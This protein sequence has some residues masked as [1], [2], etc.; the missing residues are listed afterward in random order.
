M[1]TRGSLFARM[2]LAAS[3]WLALSIGVVG[4]TLLLVGLPVYFGVQYGVEAALSLPVAHFLSAPIVTAVVATLMLSCLVAVAL[5]VRTVRTARDNAAPAGALA[6]GAVELAA[7]V[8]LLSSLL[9]ALA[10]VPF[11]RSVL[12]APLFALLILLGFL[13]LLTAGY[14]LAAYQWVHSRD[15]VDDERTTGGSYLV[16]GVFVVAYL[17]FSVWH[18]F[19]FLAAVALVWLV[20]AVLFAPDH[21][22]AVRDAI[23]R[24]AAESADEHPVDATAVYG[25]TDEAKRIRVSLEEATGMHPGILVAVAG[26]AVVSGSYLLAA[27]TSVETTA[28]AVTTL[29]GVAFIGIHV[30]STVRAETTGNSAVL[31]DLEDRFSLEPLETTEAVHTAAGTDADTALESV[32]TRLAG[33][34]AVPVP[35]VRILEDAMPIAL[36]V[37]YRPTTSTLLLSR[38]MIAELDD[39]ELE[40]VIAHE[41]SHIGNRDA[42]VL[43]A[44]AAPGALSRL[45]RSRYGYNPIVEP[46]AM[47]VNTASRW[48]VA[49]VS[50]GREYAADDGAVAIIGDPTPLASALETLSSTRS[51]RPSTDLRQRET[52]AF[53]IVPL[54]WDEH[55]FFDRTRRFLARRVFGTHPPTERRIERLRNRV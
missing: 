34:A 20:S 30:G 16:I 33:Q 17:S 22:D 25:L 13:Y 27:V 28:L 3:C 49:L 12:P 32:V 5:S 46:L 14:L 39:R 23:E 19:A 35:T 29:G 37:G 55:R 42:A 40:A 36:T 26:L 44:L 9:V 43:T 4:G 41:L 45:A 7:Y 11:F 50:R 6:Q 10:T 31:R 1:F 15:A 38:G 2:G 53:A 51:R 8:V 48:Y 52:A 54:P 21:A 47:M 24:R 18:G